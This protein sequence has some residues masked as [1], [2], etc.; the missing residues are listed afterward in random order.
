MDRLGEAYPQKS[1]K[2]SRKPPTYPDMKPEGTTNA[3][4]VD[5]DAL[6]NNW[7]KFFGHDGPGP[8]VD[9]EKLYSHGTKNQG[10]APG[11]PENVLKEKEF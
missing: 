11:V 6:Q 3:W 9:V 2:P 8:N 1:E 7:N 5:K 4:I 10:A